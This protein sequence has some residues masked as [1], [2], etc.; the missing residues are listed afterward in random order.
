MTRISLFKHEKWREKKGSDD[1]IGRNLFYVLVWYIYIILFESLRQHN[2]SKISVLTLTFLLSC[3]IDTFLDTW[4]AFHSIEDIFVFRGEIII[5]N[6]S[7]LSSWGLSRAPCNLPYI[8]SFSYWLRF[9][10][11]LF[12]ELQPIIIITKYNL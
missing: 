7:P 12:A 8:F 4:F 5:S 2:A 10:T 1:K 6:F 11:G 3:L 9:Y